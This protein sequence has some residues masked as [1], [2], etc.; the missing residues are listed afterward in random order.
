[1]AQQ[2]SSKPLLERWLVKYMMI[3]IVIITFVALAL[4]MTAY[5]RLVAILT[6]IP[7]GFVIV[8]AKKEG[9]RTNPLPW[10]I[11]L[12]FTLLE[13]YNLWLV[14]HEAS[15]SATNLSILMSFV[16]SGI[17]LGIFYGRK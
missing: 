10:L 2:L 12:F 13:A 8:M 4:N 9:S 6:F 15:K 7:T 16:L 1:M 11:A 5:S 17:S 3:G 14:F